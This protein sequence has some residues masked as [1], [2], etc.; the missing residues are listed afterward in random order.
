M[1]R[2]PGHPAARCHFTAGYVS[3]TN[4][5]FQSLEKI[6]CPS[7]STLPLPD[8]LSHMNRQPA[9]HWGPPSAFTQTSP[10][11]TARFHSRLTTSLSA[12]H[13]QDGIKSPK[14]DLLNIPALQLAFLLISIICQRKIIPHAT[15]QA[16]MPLPK[17]RPAPAPLGQRPAMPEPWAE[18]GSGSED[19]G[20]GPGHAM[21]T[22]KSVQWC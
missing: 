9:P 13:F 14:H 12:Q 3:V 4:L 19:A 15:Q 10:L 20:W 16:R 8:P 11:L 5:K 6:L 17:Q 2:E 22:A 18:L 7:T 1:T 21:R